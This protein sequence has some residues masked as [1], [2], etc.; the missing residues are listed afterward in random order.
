MKYYLLNVE[1]ILPAKLHLFLLTAV[2][3]L[4]NIRPTHTCLHTEWSGFILTGR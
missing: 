3:W 2:P 1:G 4:F